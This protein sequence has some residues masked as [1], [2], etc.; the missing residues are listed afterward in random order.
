LSCFGNLPYVKE[1][2]AIYYS[3]LKRFLRFCYGQHDI[4]WCPPTAHVTMMNVKRKAD[5]EHSFAVIEVMNRIKY[6][7]GHGPL[8]RNTKIQDYISPI[9]VEHVRPTTDISRQERKR[10]IVRMA[11]S[12]HV[13][14]DRD[15][16][17]FG[18]DNECHFCREYNISLLPVNSIHGSHFADTKATPPED[19][20][21]LVERGPRLRGLPSR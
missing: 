20:P 17:V 3:L 11:H 21:S 10:Q 15:V 5:I 2:L 6:V 18:D 13:F 4:K 12:V 19:W 9:T 7:F 8:A 1:R 16:M 14:N